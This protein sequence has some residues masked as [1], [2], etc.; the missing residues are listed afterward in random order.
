MLDNTNI[1]V[2]SV[3]GE[4]CPFVGLLYSY[5]INNSILRGLLNSSKLRYIGVML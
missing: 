3:C 1:L 4:L 5:I 2:C